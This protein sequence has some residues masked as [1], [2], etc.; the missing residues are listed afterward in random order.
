MR[1][2]CVLPLPLLV[3]GCATQ[4]LT[5]AG[6]VSAPSGKFDELYFRP[7]AD[8]AVYRRV[9]IEPV[10]VKF[11]AD[12]LSQQHGLN[13]LLAQ[14][15]YRPYQD[16]EE[17]ARDYSTLMQAS[18]ADAFKSAN[19]EVVSSGGLGVLRVVARI[20]ELF[21]NAPDRLSSSVRS[22][23]NRD[24]GQ[25]TL[26]LEASDSVSGNVLARVVHRNIVREVSRFNLADDSSNRFWFETAFR[27]WAGNV[28]AELGSSGRT[29]VS[30][31]R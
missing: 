13:Y 15:M 7:N 3:A 22:T 4:T 16:A 18:L 20:D 28:T 26:S 1:A 23:F 6:L 10:A 2:L 29:R 9:V 30:E 31:A 27:R 19:Y 11:R 12:Y 24:T 8:L 21:I 25:A 17:I 14:P 5:S